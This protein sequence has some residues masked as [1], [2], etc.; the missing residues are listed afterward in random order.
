[1]ACDGRNPAILSDFPIQQLAIS[2][3]QLRSGS[4]PIVFI[5][6]DFVVIDSRPRGSGQK[7]GK[8]AFLLEGHNI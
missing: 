5:C 8:S 3:Q 2:N 6:D 7:S 1:M 4:L